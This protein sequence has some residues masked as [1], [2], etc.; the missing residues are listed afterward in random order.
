MHALR[1]SFVVI[2]AEPTPCD[3]PLRP[4]FPELF[5]HCTDCKYSHECSGWKE[6]LGSRVEVHTDICK[7]EKMYVETCSLNATEGENCE[8]RIQ[9]RADCKFLYSLVVVRIIVAAR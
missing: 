2:V 9:K 6:K 8:P 4:F 3:S 7:S 1:Y 5:K